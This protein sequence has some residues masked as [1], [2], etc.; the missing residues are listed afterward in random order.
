MMAAVFLLANA[1][2]ASAS[3]RYDPRLRFRT[4]S[5]ARFDIHFHQ[6]EQAL[7][8]RLAAFIEDAAREV[9]ASVGASVGRVQVI[10]VDQHDVSNGWATPLPYNTI[11]ISAAAP[12]ADSVLGNTSDWLRLVFTHEYTHIAHLSRARGW[13]GGLRRGFGRLPLLFPNLYQPI[14]GIEGIATWEESAATGEGRVP[15]GD[16]RT[17]LATAA[18]GRRFEPLDRVNGGNVDW[19]GGNM[20]Y[21]YGAYFHA[22]LAQ[23][24]GADAVRRLADETAGQIPYFT[25]RAYRKV[26]GRSLGELWTAFQRSS[27]LESTSAAPTTVAGARRLT[28][29]GFV[30]ASPRYAPDGRVFYAV[31]DPHR[32]PAVME[33]TADGRS[34]RQVARRY[35]GNRIAISGD[36]LVA[37]EID[38]VR[39]VGTGSD[40]YLFDPRNGR[41]RRLTR[42]ARALDPDVRH[43]EVVCAIQ[44]TGRRA[45]ATFRLAPDGGLAQPAVLIDEPDADFAAPRW[46]PDG[47]MIA[48]ERRRLGGPAEIVLVDVATRTVRTVANVAGGRSSSPA[49]MP[50]GTA[51]LF[52]SAIENGEFRIFRADMQS[53]AVNYLDGTGS[54]QSPDVSPDGRTIVYV[55]YTADGYDLYSVALDA[56]RQFPAR[57]AADAAAAPPPVAASAPR[58]QD[59]PYSPAPT[60]LPTFW[61]PTLET[62][63]DELVVGAATGS[64]DALGRHA[65][66]VEAGWSSRARPDWQVAYA[67]DRW[68]PTLFAAVSDDTDPWREGDVR[69]VDVDAG[70]ILRV[71]RVRFSHA[72]FLALHAGQD[73]FQCSACE[74]AVDVRQRTRSVRLGW[75]FTNARSF[76]YSISAEEGGRFTATLDVPRTA[77]GSD[78][79]GLAATVDARRYFRAWPGH[80]AI[81][82]RGAAAASSGEDEALREF[83]AAGNGPVLD[84]FDFGHDAI[85]LLRGVDESDVVGTRAAVVNLDYRVPVARIDRGIGTLP[86]FFRAVH[87]A[88]FLDVGHAWTDAPRWSDRQSSI[89]AEIAVDTVVG[90]VVPVTFAA[91]VAWRHDGRDGTRDVAFF[92]RVG[93]AF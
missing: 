38:I 64:A 58:D 46:S 89:G 79:N 43:S 74:P 26:F 40:I 36:Y 28:H 83:T 87:A 37:D 63:A 48:A 49:W 47:R 62:D 71:S 54:A 6:G 91:G 3:L 32:F 93:R 18:R 20:P 70:A 7:A 12:R 25:A 4:I 75:S 60:I 15:A 39:N 92:G 85:G 72:T 21:L 9:D 19:P 41:R 1:W 24:Y 77:L 80:G 30:V 22:Y 29:H 13:I 67:Y 27:E 2:V 33:L 57:V 73:G 65:Y 88:A 55:G 52:S 44:L 35:F 51:I 56:P 59:R 17:Q 69:S 53:G 11:E 8:R 61:T 23:E 10:L 82:L 45:L 68:W 84:G 42:H 78:G 86:V 66:G 16:F 14:W 34:A 50:D 76:G 31:S 90:F 5:T 81:A